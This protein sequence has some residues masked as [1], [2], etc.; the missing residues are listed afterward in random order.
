MFNS[1]KTILYLFLAFVFAINNIAIATKSNIELDEISKQEIIDRLSAFTH[2]CK[3][4][5]P[6]AKLA[7]NT[8][9]DSSGKNR[10]AEDIY[11]KYCVAC[12]LA[13]IL[14]AP[15]KGNSQDWKKHLA[16]HKGNFNDMW[17]SAIKGIGAMPPRGNCSNCSDDEIKSTIEFM[18]GLRP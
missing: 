11:N 10:T 4:N 8:L 18:S 17:H 15:K 14:G 7:N 16:N 12:H 2:S 13:G 1:L 3:Q 9:E 6:C 5:E